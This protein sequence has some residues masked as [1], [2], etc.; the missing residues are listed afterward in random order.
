MFRLLRVG[1][2]QVGKALLSRQLHRSQQ[3]L[4]TRSATAVALVLTLLPAASGC[5][6]RGKAATLSSEETEK[7]ASY[8]VAEM[9][10][11]AKKL[12][13]NFDDKV[14]A[15]G[16][17]IEP[18][19]APPGTQVTVTT[20]WR[21]DGSL[22]G[23]WNLFTHGRDDNTGSFENLDGT[24]RLREM[25]G[26]EQIYGPSHWEKGRIYA[27]VQTITVPDSGLATGA[28]YVIKTGIYHGTN[29]LK[30]LAGP[31][32]GENGGLIARVKT[33]RT[34]K[35]GSEVPALGVPRLSKPG[36]IV[37]DGKADEAAWATAADTGAFVNVSNGKPDTG[38]AVG[39]H[40]R[41]L[42]DD[43]NLYVFFDAKDTN[44]QGGYTDSKAAPQLFTATGQPKLW[45]RDTVEIMLDPD[46]D[47]DNIDYYELQVNPQNRVFHTQYDGY[48]TPKV[49]PNGPFG[50]EDWDPKLKSAVV[51]AGTLDD[52]KPDTGYSVEIAIPWA[53]FSKAKKH[54]PAAGD[55]WR[56][57][58]YVMK[59][60]GGLAWSPI[61]G[62]GNFHKA[63][64]FG[65]VT[66]GGVDGAI[67]TVSEPAPPRPHGVVKLPQ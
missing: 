1:Y 43:D 25:R 65:R 28:E 61:L 34:P 58:F 19:L 24:G 52:D 20:Y 13:I 54:P 39:G 7:L 30:I 67:P 16:V 53:A 37:I 59:D 66:W 48:N 45:E 41:M 46:G 56:M 64:R 8:A 50:H 23:T 22:D 40:A 12:D 9:P 42:F 10:A 2:N 4:H 26:D 38:A 3:T 62:Q 5:V 44:L 15:L 36:L 32:D 33:G 60:N 11:N 47:G 35:K 18:E 49:D 55:T 14:R 63:T 57:N 17:V 31:S 29:R 6:T 27:D 51:L 21:R